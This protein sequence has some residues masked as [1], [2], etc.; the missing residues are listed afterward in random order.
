[1]I[2]DLD[3]GVRSEARSALHDVR[4]MDNTDSEGQTI[5]WDETVGT[6]S[7]RYDWAKSTP[8]VGITQMVAQI[9]ETDPTELIPL[10]EYTNTDALNTIIGDESRNVRVSFGYDRF[11]VSVSSTGAVTLEPL[12]GK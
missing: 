4:G 7:A 6:Y 9:E 8:S 12:D 1:M 11:R 2:V 5:T 3:A 10:H